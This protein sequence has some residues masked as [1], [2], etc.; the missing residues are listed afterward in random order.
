[1]AA[2]QAATLALVFCVT[3]AVHADYA[4]KAASGQELPTAPGG[5]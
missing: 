5:F 4:T 3:P 1:M 2:L